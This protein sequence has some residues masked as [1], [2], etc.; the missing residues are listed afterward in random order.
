VDVLRDALE[1]CGVVEFVRANGSRGIDDA[2][3]LELHRGWCRSVVECLIDR[4][5]SKPTFGRAAKLKRAWQK[6]TWTQLSEEDYYPLI[7]QFRAAIRFREPFW[8]LERFGTVTT[9]SD[10]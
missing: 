3:F 9:E 5:V 4:G 8:N 1:N 7:G 2:R 6:E 10:L